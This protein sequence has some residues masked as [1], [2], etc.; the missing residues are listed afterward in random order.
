MLADPR[1]PRYEFKLN[2]ARTRARANALGH[3]LGPFLKEPNAPH[4]AYAECKDARCC[5]GVTI[6]GDNATGAAIVHKC[7]GRTL[8]EKK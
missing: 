1:P 7:V 4:L 6:D 2:K 3:N 5:L 8:E